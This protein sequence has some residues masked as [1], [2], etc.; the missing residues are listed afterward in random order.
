MRSVLISPV[1]V[2]AALA[3][4][5]SLSASSTDIEQ[6]YATRW[7]VEPIARLA[8]SR[9]LVINAARCRIDEGQR[10]GSWING[11]AVGAVLGRTTWR[12]PVDTLAPGTYKVTYDLR[13]PT[14]AEWIAGSLR[15]PQIARNTG[16]AGERNVL[17]APTSWPQARYPK[18]ACDEGP[19]EFAWD[20]E[21]LYA[22][23]TAGPAEI[24]ID[25]LPAVPG[26]YVRTLA[27]DAPM[28]I[29][30]SEISPAAPLTGQVLRYRINKG[31]S[32]WRDLLFV[33]TGEKQYFG[34]TT[35]SDG[36]GGD[37]QGPPA[38]ILGAM[39]DLSG[40]DLFS[41]HIAWEE[42]EAT[43]P[44]DGPHS[45]DWSKLVNNPNL[46]KNGLVLVN[47][48]LQN[49][50]A[51]PIKSTDPERY[52]RLAEDFVYEAV[53]K[54]RSAGVKC[55][56]LG[57]NEPE[58]FSRTDSKDYF[59]THLTHCANAARRAAPDA[60][61]FAGRFSSGSPEL[62]CE[63][64]AHGFRDNFDVLDIHPY[65][66]DA[67]LGTAE[68]E[69]VASHQALAALGMGNK[70]IFLGEG[71]GPGRELSYVKRT[72]WDEPVSP[73]EADYTRLY[74]QNGYRCMVTARADFSPDW[75]LGGKYFT[76]NDNVGSTYWKQSAKPVFSP[77]GEL[78]GYMIGELQFA[79]N[80]DFTARFFNGGLL[81]F[82]AKPKGQWFYDFPP[83]LPEVRVS[84]SRGPAYVLVGEYHQVDVTVVNAN[85][86]AITDV[87]LGV[88]DRSGKFRGAISAQAIGDLTRPSLAPGEIWH[89]SVRVR[90][91]KG[92]PR[93]IRWALEVQYKYDGERH[94]SDDIVPTEIRNPVD[95]VPS[96][97]RVVLDGP[98]AQTV[99][100]KVRN[101]ERQA[102]SF[103]P[104]SYQGADFASVPSRS[105]IQLDSGQETTY[106]IDIRPGK[107]EPGV[108]NLEMLGGVGT[109]IAVVTPLDCPR[110]S[111]APK[112]DGDLS[113]WPAE[114][115][116]AG[117]IRFG[118]DVNQ[119]ERPAVDPFP[120]P[121][122]AAQSAL[123]SKGSSDQ[124]A[125]GKA[126]TYTYGANA[127]VAWDE[128]ALYLAVMVED[129]TH[130]Q[131][132]TGADVWKEDSVQ[133]AFDPLNNGDTSALLP[134]SEMKAGYGPDDYELSL[135]LTGLGPQVAIVTSPGG[136]QNGLVKDA[137]LAVR[138]DGKFTIYEARIPKGVI[139]G[140]ILKPGARFGFD[141]LINN[142]EQGS[143]Y[144]LG[145]AGGIGNGK[146][147]GK[148]VPVVLR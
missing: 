71:W 14:G 88:R 69:V 31:G 121:P 73:E 94:M 13:T 111:S 38:E 70:R 55:F 137:E 130:T 139:H 66:M 117:S 64:Y 22:R 37:D 2:I 143:R 32:E 122:P 119:A 40:L 147:P 76:L 19:V 106:T 136:G 133:I 16:Q 112:I 118:T 43:N 25:P 84:A 98:T 51:E 35:V 142:V 103:K 52:W 110:V 44:G 50:W 46:Y 128:A 114:Q 91:D 74:Y 3:V 67:M 85:P 61:V 126:K 26:K 60:V 124:A 146:Y 138:R 17:I 104:V 72:K 101:N 86:R 79:P 97:A 115:V 102:A 58:M 107:P 33:G 109:V 105:R 39:M 7:N 9:K 75:V 34:A 12:I 87:K 57:Y 120:K 108:R 8:M 15:V 95:V 63:F 125:D 99:S 93:P 48:N 65:T 53:R 145:W 6:T 54:C 4:A 56:T 18:I 78:M 5:P 89:G 42:V 1:L 59:N 10:A 132:F 113:D 90:V 49:S 62:I 11:R 21:N 28:K 141:V 36:P 135:A 116:K 131:R 127:A 100:V 81:D 23:P 129:E 29:A 96:E 148:F 82:F 20:H 30:W 27:V 144:T 24:V 140:L 134:G 83:A 92:T 80:A 47:I 77:K 68:G 123:D 41:H 45:Y